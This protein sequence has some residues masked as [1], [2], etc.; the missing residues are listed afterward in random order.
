[1]LLLP[2]L[3]LAIPAYIA[4]VRLRHVVTAIGA[5]HRGA[6]LG[7]SRFHGDARVGRYLVANA[8]GDHLSAVWDATGLAA[9]SLEHAHRRGEC[10]ASLRVAPDV[11]A[12][13]PAMARLIEEALEG[14][15]GHATG[16][17]W[18]VRGPGGDTIAGGEVGNTVWLET[19]RLGPTDLLRHVHG[20]HGWLEEHD[21]TPA[22]GKVATRLART[23]TP[24]AIAASDGN[25]LLA[26][27]PLNRLPTSEGLAIAVELLGDVGVTWPGAADALAH[28]LAKES[29]RRRVRD[30]DGGLSLLEAVERGDL[31]AVRALVA[32]G[33]NLDAT[34]RNGELE[35][36]WLGP[37]QTPLIV[38]INLWHDAIAELLVVAG[39]D[40]SRRLRTTSPLMLAAEHGLA[41]VC[42]LLIERGADLHAEEPG[43]LLRVVSHGVANVRGQA[44]EVVRILLDAGASL[45]SPYDCDR[46]VRVAQEAGARDLVA[47]LTSAAPDG[48]E[49]GEVVP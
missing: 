33:A 15:G 3:R 23:T 34:S 18:L 2:A 42:R 5:I 39:A 26:P 40:V 48:E 11:Q 21:V 31:E 27:R 4:A 22:Q 8:S 1:M 46:L 49:G 37:G 43:A 10:E 7:T 19:H 17:R 35:K 16:L 45:P 14:I 28:R 47:R 41:R 32:G 30:A 20:S 6:P 36:D 12:A 24:Q 9:A 44:A 25:V 29:A 13:P 38:A